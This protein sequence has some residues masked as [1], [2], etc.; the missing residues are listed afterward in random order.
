MRKISEL[1]QAYGR[2]W[3]YIADEYAEEFC[4][5]LCE[6]GARFQNGDA[7]TAD[8]IGNIMGVHADGVV[9]Y[10]SYMI[11]YNTFSVKDAPVKV[12][13]AKYHTGQSDFVFTEPN[14]VPLG[15]K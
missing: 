9:G 8:N 13:Y 3:F 10:V 15:W 11:W 5:E 4:A 1:L 7:V 6:F 12:D 14:I 2:V